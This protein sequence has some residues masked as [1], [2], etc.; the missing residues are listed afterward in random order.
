MTTFLSTTIPYVN[1]APHI[2]FA[3]EAVQ[4]DVLA[5]HRAAARRT[6]AAAVRHRRQLAEERPRRRGRRR[7]RAAPSST[8]TPSRFA[9]LAGPL[10]LT[11]DDFIRTSRDP[12]HR[13]GVEALWRACA[14][15]GDLYQATLRRPLL[16]RL[17]A[18]PHAGRTRSGRPL[19]GAR[20]CRRSASPNATGSSG[21]PATPT[22]SRDAIESGELRIDPAGAPQRGA[23][24]HRRRPARLLRLAI[25]RARP[26]AGASRSPATRTR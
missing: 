24:V 5:R 12:R 6:R 16:R 18:L 21:C 10:S 23:R 11:Y 26:A 20:R 8:R 7:R 17:R 15:A 3:L 13:V 2:G 19:P 1:A 9:A 14:A 22:G 25:R 4:A